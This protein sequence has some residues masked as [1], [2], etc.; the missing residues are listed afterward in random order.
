MNDLAQFQPAFNGVNTLLAVSTNIVTEQITNGNLK[1]LLY[2][3]WWYPRLLYDIDGNIC[4]CC[5][6][7]VAAI[8]WGHEIEEDRHTRIFA[9]LQQFFK[10][11]N[12]L[13]T[14]FFVLCCRQGTRCAKWIYLKRQYTLHI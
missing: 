11:W 7:R 14:E 6:I 12:F 9:E 5:M 10:G 3:F 2:I 8:L 4:D 13:L 1:Q